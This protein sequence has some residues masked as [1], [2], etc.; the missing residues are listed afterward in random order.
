MEKNNH[1]VDSFDEQEF[2]KN[3]DEKFLLPE[4]IKQINKVRWLEQQ[5][6]FLSLGFQ[7]RTLIGENKKKKKKTEEDK[8]K[9]CDF[10]KVEPV[11]FSKEAKIKGVF[12]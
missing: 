2:L 6:Q 3:K 5:G 7:E 8:M 10:I 11:Y 4:E 12:D 1:P 9:N